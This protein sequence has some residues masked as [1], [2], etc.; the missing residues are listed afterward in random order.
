MFGSWVR[1]LGEINVNPKAVLGHPAATY[2]VPTTAG[3]PTLDCLDRQTV[4]R[5]VLTLLSRGSRRWS[6]P[7]T[8]LEHM[9]SPET[10]W[11]GR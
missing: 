2:P 1:Q 7:R 11:K 4:G 3:C 9:A 6:I 10:V 5:A 8:M